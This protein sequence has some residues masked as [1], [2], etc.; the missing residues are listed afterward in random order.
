MKPTH[1]RIAA[2]LLALALLLSACGKK[3]AEKKDAY[4]DPFAEVMN[5]TARWGILLQGETAQTNNTI[6]QKRFGDACVL[7]V[8]QTPAWYASGSGRCFTGIIQGTAE[9][10]VFCSLRLCS[11]QELFLRAGVYTDYT[12]LVKD[13]DGK[14]AYTG[15]FE[16]PDYY[17]IKWDLA[18]TCLDGKTRNLSDIGR[19][20]RYGSQGFSLQDPTDREG[21]TTCLAELSKLIEKYNPG[22]GDAALTLNQETGELELTGRIEAGKSVNLKLELSWKWVG[23]DEDRVSADT[24][25]KADKLLGNLAAE[26]FSPDQAGCSNPDCYS[27]FLNADAEFTLRPAA[28]AN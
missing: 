17:P 2:V 7:T 22:L 8:K 14:A 19:M 10:D 16:T 3:S 26:A 15:T 24:A 12:A 21:L 20:R 9:A 1:L 11:L 18:V 25:K 4:A 27:A 6:Y 5:R 13:A 28:A 23:C